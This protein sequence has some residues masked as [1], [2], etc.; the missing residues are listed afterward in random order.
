MPDFGSVGQTQAAIARYLLPLTVLF[1]GLALLALGY[2]AKQRHGYG[3]L[4]LGII[5][6]LTVMISKF[7][8]NVP[9]LTYV[10]LGLLILASLW[11]IRFN[12]AAPESG[13]VPPM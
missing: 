8:L 1:F 2:Q 13:C 7:V 11:N 5:A 10:G 6:A 3:P 12:K 4:G 9:V